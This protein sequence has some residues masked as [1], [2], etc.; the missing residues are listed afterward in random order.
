MSVN[1][2]SGMKLYDNDWFMRYNWSVEQLTDYLAAHNIT[3][4][5]AQSRFLPMDNSAVQ[6]A[7]SE[8]DRRRYEALDDVVLRQMLRDRDIAYIAVQNICFDPSYAAE[9][10]EALP[11]DQHGE[12]MEQ[13][14]WYVGVPP[15][16]Q[17]NIRQ[18]GQKLKEAV[19]ALDPDGVHLGFIRWPGFWETWLPGDQRG[20][21]PEYCF[22]PQT[23]EDFNRFAG[24]SL[25]P[26]L[27]HRNAPDLMQ[28]YRAEWTRYKCEATRAAIAE[29][30]GCFEV[31]KDPL[32]V[33]INT[34]PLFA[35]EFDGAVTEVYGQDWEM[36]KDVVDVFE[37]MAYHQ[38]CKRDARWPAEIAEHIKQRSGQRAICTVQASALYLD[39]MHQEQKRSPTLDAHE[40]SRMLDALESTDVDGLCIFTL[41]ELMDRAQT[42]DGQMMLD[43]LSRFR[44]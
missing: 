8:D 12:R 2:R 10:P 43:R 37:V 18:K 6:S 29:L 24:L 34:V 38:I 23:I 41:T 3:Y 21:K 16:R 36:L 7:I 35:D 11:I 30:R 13:T 4:V 31:G 33:S 32:T 27:G 28:R 17:D 1:F 5:I 39:G 19:D 40:F 25:D 15:I 42:K 20:D 14:D 22:A 9:H 26:G 44:L